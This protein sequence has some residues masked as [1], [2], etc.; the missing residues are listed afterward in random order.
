MKRFFILA[1]IG[2]LFI[3]SCGKKVENPAQNQNQTLNIVLGNL[4]ETSGHPGELI[5][6]TTS[7]KLDPVGDYG[8]YFGDTFVPILQ[9]ED[10]YFTIIPSIPAGQVELK[11]KN[12]KENRFSSATPFV[13]KDIMQTNMPPGEIM[14]DMVKFNKNICEVLRT[15][16]IPSIQ[17][18][19][20]MNNNDTD[21]FSEHLLKY[22]RAFSK[23]NDQIDQYSEKDREQIDALLKAA[24][25]LDLFKQQNGIL[26]KVSKPCNTESIYAIHHILIGLD[27][28]SAML[29]VSGDAVMLVGIAATVGSF[30]AAA[31]V[32]VTA[33]LLITGI[34][35]AIDGFI[36]TDLNK[37]YIENDPLTV[38]YN[39]QMDVIIMGKFITQSN[40]VNATFNVLLSSVLAKLPAN[41][42]V[43]KLSLDVQELASKLGFDAGTDMIG[44][45]D[46]WNKIDNIITQ[47]DPYIYTS[48]IDGVMS[49]LDLFG[50]SNP[51]IGAITQGNLLFKFLSN[52]LGINY[53]VEN[54]NI[55][56]FNAIKSELSGHHYGNS[57]LIYNGY[58]FKSPPL[59]SIGGF[60][61]NFLG[62]EV[63]IK[64]DENTDVEDAPINVTALDANT[65]YIDSAP[66]GAKIY[67]DDTY[68]NKVTP[69]VL[70]N[71]SEGEHSI[72]LIKAGYNDYYTTFSL[73]ENGAIKINA[74]LGPPLPPL[75]IF[76]IDTPRNNEHFTNNVVTVSGSISLRD[77]FGNESAFGGQEAILQLN[78]IDQKIPV[79]NGNFKQEILINSGENHLQLRANNENGDT[80]TSNEI[81]IYGDFSVEDIQ[82]VLKWNNG[83]NQNGDYAQMKDV[84]LHV[85]DSEGHHTYWLCMDQY[86]NF[87]GH[88]KAVANMIPGSKLDIDNTWGFGPETFTLK[89]S[90]NTTYTVRAHFYSGY[91]ASNP[92][93]ANVEITLRGKNTKTYGPYKFG[94][95]YLLRNFDGEY[96]NN[97]NYDDPDCWWD[98]ISFSVS[99]GLL[100]FKNPSQQKYRNTI[101]LGVKKEIAQK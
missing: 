96:I 7:P 24:G 79:N 28:L 92:T 19:H 64:L 26:R 55:A 40:P 2:L 42:L 60:F 95:S 41:D 47:I 23:L 35:N 93:Y 5:H 83:T 98:V 99:G 82:I 17:G 77:P 21:L 87:P 73:S 6:F 11:L 30:G 85:Y 70:R 53:K 29:S 1:I 100:I 69:N 48:G 15:S 37:L 33:S 91:D 68:M 8:I 67:L 3:V 27:A 63:P 84:D 4:S 58:C 56:T 52:I 9:D 71:V 49:V 101:K 12:E 66:E 78:G 75:P 13:V 14:H 62:L 20:I 97:T 54:N 43:Q 36:P 18:A 39:G 89:K 59:S 50:I 94:N 74:I 22:E 57:R 44:F 46:K 90:T 51:L 34:D 61:T 88:D 16:I 38:P 65:I 32:A 81:V 25:T 72:R 86:S 10:G 31:P 45:T 80:G 76:T